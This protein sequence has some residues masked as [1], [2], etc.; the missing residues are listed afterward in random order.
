L[1]LL[2]FGS[3]W[4]SS[5]D[6]TLASPR[7]LGE[8]GKRAALCA[9]WGL[10]GGLAVW[11]HL[12]SLAVV[13]PAAFGLAWSVRRERVAFGAIALGLLLGSAPWWMRLAWDPSATAVISVSGE[14]GEAWAHLRDLLPRWHEPVLGLLGAHTP[15]SADDPVHRVGLPLSGR[16]ALALL[17][18]LG[19][20]RVARIMHRAWRGGGEA[21]RRTVARAL[22]LG[23]AVLLT[24]G[25]FPWPLRSGPETLRFLAPAYLPLAVLVAWAPAA[26]GHRR[27]AWVTALTLALLHLLPATRLLE[28]WRASSPEHP[29]LPDCRP[30][31]SLLEQR[32]V[33]RAWASYDTAW[34]L[35]YLSEGRVLA[36]QPWNERFP[37]VPPRFRDD[38]RFEGDAAWVLRPDA[39][40]DLPRPEAFEAFVRETGGGLR[41]TEVGDAVVYDRFAAP[42][43]AEGVPWPGAGAAGDGDLATRVVEPGRGATTWRLAQP[44]GLS[45]VTLAGGVEPPGL[46][47]GFRVEVSADGLTFER[48][49][50]LR[51]DRR[52]ALAWILGQPQPREGLDVL[53]LPLRGRAVAA[54]RVTPQ[55]EQGPWGLAELLLHPAGET[56]SVLEPTSDWGP[57]WPERRARLVARPQPRRADWLARAWLARRPSGER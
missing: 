39:D 51:A 53:T 40:F 56:E 23:A 37:D 27:G 50:R 14:A 3:L 35:A 46:P 36:S 9:A 41:R 4:L 20:L 34:C 21:G 30:V 8:T 10:L 6:L 12:V 17:Y 5:P 54:L 48:V 28:A 44:L 33:R 31:L 7:G 18:G 47:R 16:L 2:L 55:P 13:L 32:G 38:V 1:G 45:A 15:T 29:L 52:P 43:A 57:T 19:L 24:I 11:T 42:F 25:A 26:E 22:V 49:A